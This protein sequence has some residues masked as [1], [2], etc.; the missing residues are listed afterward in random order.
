MTV[1]NDEQIAQVNGGHPVAAG[2]G[3][4]G[5]VILILEIPHMFMGI[6]EFTNYV[7]ERWNNGC[8]NIDEN[9]Y[10]TKFFCGC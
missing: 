4:L 8:Q 10:F 9:D 6:V 5:T 2:L 1:L 3:I 7:G